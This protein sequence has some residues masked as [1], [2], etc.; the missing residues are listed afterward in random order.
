MVLWVKNLSAMACRGT[1][2]ISSLAQWVKKDLALP[3]LQHRL[4]LL[5]RFNPW[6][7]ELPYAT[8]KVIKIKNK[9]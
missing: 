2:L 1:G 4:Q 9:M 5:F 8:G 3:Q 6:P 7:Q